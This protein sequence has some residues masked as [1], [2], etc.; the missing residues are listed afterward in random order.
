MLMHCAM[1]CCTRR[2]FWFIMYYPAQPVA[3][4][5]QGFNDLL[6]MTVCTDTTK[7]ITAMYEPYYVTNNLTQV[8]GKFWETFGCRFV[9]AMH[10]I[11]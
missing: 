9:W 3:F 5:A 10:D 7:D 1:R 4:C 6:P 8:G 2:C 11:Y